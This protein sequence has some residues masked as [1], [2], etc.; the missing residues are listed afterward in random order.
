MGKNKHKDDNAIAFLINYDKT[1]TM[2]DAR[3]IKKKLYN[4]SNRIRYILLPVRKFD[5]VNYFMIE[6]CYY[7]MDIEYFSVDG[8]LALQGLEY[9]YSSNENAMNVFEIVSG[10]HLDTNSELGV[11]DIYESLAVILYFNE[12]IN[13]T[14]CEEYFML[15]FDNPKMVIQKRGMECINE[16]YN[17]SFLD[18]RHPSEDYGS[19][20]VVMNNLIKMVYSDKKG[21]TCPEDLIY[22]KNSLILIASGKI[23]FFEFPASGEQRIRNLRKI[24]K[25]ASKTN[26][27]IG[28]FSLSIGSYTFMNANDFLLVSLM[29]CTQF[30]ICFYE[31]NKDLGDLPS[32]HVTMAMIEEDTDMFYENWAISADLY[33]TDRLIELL[34]N[35]KCIANYTNLYKDVVLGKCIDEILFGVVGMINI[36]QLPFKSTKNTL[37][38]EYRYEITYSKLNEIDD[39]MCDFVSK[40]IDELRD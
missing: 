19:V 18:K 20:S 2:V 40:L 26:A 29:E 14:Y 38:Y 31:V 7:P 24:S 16:T 32:E 37:R 34:A 22:T 5:N 33:G 3:D 13:P 4:D 15:S 36:N 28:V 8:T 27:V 1:Y 11:Y 6:A 30:Q 39:V 17:K 23:E 12:L 25:I 21:I 35:F 9:G 10:I